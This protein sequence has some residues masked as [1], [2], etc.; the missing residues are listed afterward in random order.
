VD[1]ECRSCGGKDL[2][3]VLS[4]GSMPLANALL[5]EKQLGEP[6]TKWPLDL[7]FCPHCALVQI[8]ETVPPEILFRDYLYFSSYSDTMLKHASDLSD[9]LVQRMGLNSSSLVVELGSNDGYLLKYFARRGV[10]VLGVEPALNVAKVAEQSGVP[11]VVEFF[12]EE[13]ARSLGRQGRSATAIIAN[14]VLAH[15]ADLPGFVRGM[16]TLLKDGGRI[17]VEVPY[18]K[19]MIDRCEFDTIYHE[20]LCYFSLTALDEL[21]RRG[22]LTVVDVERLPIHGG[23]LRVYAAHRAEE[24]SRAVRDLLLEEDGWGVRHVEAYLQFGRAVEDLK[25][26]LRSLLASL[27]SEGKH[28]AGYGAAAKATVLLNYCG[29]GKESLDFVADRSPHKQG[30]YIPGTHIPISG[31]ERLLQDMPHYTVLFAWNLADEILKQQAQYRERGG[32]FV[33][34]VPQATI[35]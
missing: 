29:I 6:E 2:E 23:S 9:K 27:K 14:N 19:D 31:P 13:L 25:S 30:R 1:G 18:V 20:H 33:L 15:V 26:S 11:T 8:T 12:G 24:R 16:G 32:K 4:L 5:T 28:I 34:P 3:L 21:F 7:A 17:I 10:P 22:G 35:V